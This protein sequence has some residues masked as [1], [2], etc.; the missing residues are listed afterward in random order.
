[1]IGLFA[2]II[3][4]WIF[5]EFDSTFRVYG[6]YPMNSIQKQAKQNPSKPQLCYNFEAPER[7][8]GKTHFDEINSAKNNFT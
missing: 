7:K 5:C 6:L 2:T 4:L 8:I 1:M 3:F